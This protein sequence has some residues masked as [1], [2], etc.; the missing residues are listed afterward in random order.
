[1]LTHRLPA[2]RLLLQHVS[3][4]WLGNCN[5]LPSAISK[6]CGVWRCDQGMV[7]NVVL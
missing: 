6:S 7:L 3:L 2:V 5:F 1:M 4:E